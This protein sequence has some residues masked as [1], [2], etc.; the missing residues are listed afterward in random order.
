MSV[1]VPVV[2]V[3][4]WMTCSVYLQFD[5]RWFCHHTYHSLTPASAGYGG[6]VD[7]VP[8]GQGG[9][10]DQRLIYEFAKQ[11]NFMAIGGGGHTYNC[12][13][14]KCLCMSTSFEKCTLAVVLDNGYPGDVSV[15][16][17]QDLTG[18]TNVG[19]HCEQAAAD[20]Q[21][22][23]SRTVGNIKKQYEQWVSF[24]ERVSYQWLSETYPCL[25][26]NGTTSLSIST[27]FQTT[28]S[29]HY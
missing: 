29:V 10:E 22:T 13:D 11:L 18:L 9:T 6:C 24:S 1:W 12:F 21:I 20:L 23:S 4:V 5:D 25:S 28:C 27:S 14:V 17:Y 26:F 19:S 15:P 3:L 8:S 7:E 2:L 16:V